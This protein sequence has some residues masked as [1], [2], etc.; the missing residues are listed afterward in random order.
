V[1]HATKRSVSDPFTFLT[2]PDPDFPPNM[3]PDPKPDKKHIWEF[4]LKKV[5]YL[6]RNVSMVE[7]LNIT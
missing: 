7:F 3:D 1:L 6:K 2:D 5:F 4:E